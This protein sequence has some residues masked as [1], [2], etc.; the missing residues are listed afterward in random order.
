MKKQILSEEFRRMQKL[1][2]II[3]ENKNIEEVSLS[4]DEQKI[5]DDIVGTLNEGMFSDVLNKV[6][7]YAKK[8]LI[9]VAIVAS[10]LGGGM[11]TLDQKQ[12]VVDAVKTEMP[13]YE[14]NPELKHISDA[15]SV[16]LN[17]ENNKE[18]IDSLAQKDEDVQQLVYTLKNTDLSKEGTDAAIMIGQNNQD[19][20]KKIDSLVFNR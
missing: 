8:G 7:N 6:K 16:Y 17:Y 20:I 15:Y 9:T 18:K 4:S 5:F 10:L 2:G 1:A 12:D 11:L 14:K 13:A 19:A 3:V